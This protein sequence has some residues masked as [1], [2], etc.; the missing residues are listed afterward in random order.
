MYARVARFESVNVEVAERTSDE[1][2]AIIRPLIDGLDGYRGHLELVAS[3]GQVLSITLF[4]SEADVQTAEPTFDEEMPRK[5][6]ELF[7][8]G[9][10]GRRL[11]VQTYKV[12]AEERR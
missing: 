7:S 3:D 4:D 11:S 5:L 9:W 8:A 1:A 12:L 6:G 10:E 2:E